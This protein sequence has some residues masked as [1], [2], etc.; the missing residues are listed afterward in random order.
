MEKIKKI[1]RYLQYDIWRI[2]IIGTQGRNI[3]FVK[4]LRMLILTFKGFIEDNCVLRAS[5]LTFFTL[6]SIVP[7]FAMAFGIAKGFGLDKNL[8]A[9]LKIAFQGQQE[10]LNQILEF[11][12]NQLERT[13]GGMVAGLGVLL[14]FW[15]I[16]KLMGNMENALN[17]IWG[18]KMGRTLGRKIVEYVIV[19]VV[20][21]LLLI[22]S[23]GVTAFLTTYATLGVNKFE[24]LQF[25]G[26]YLL[27]SLK[28]VPL[29]FLWALFSFL[30]TFMPNTKVSILSGLFA[31]AVSALLFDLTQFAYF[32]FQVVLFTQYSAIYGS[33]AAMPLFLIWLEVSWMIFLLGAEIA[34]SHQ[35]VDTF[36]FDHDIKKISSR[37][38]RELQLYVAALIAE[39]FEN[40]EPPLS[41]NQLTHDHAMPY[42]LAKMIL[43]DLVKAGVATLVVGNGIHEEDECYQPALTTAKLTVESVSELLES[44]GVDDIP[45]NK[46]DKFKRVSEILEEMRMNNRKSKRN[47][48]LAKI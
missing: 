36:E 39:R 14:L 29:L 5:S 35:N 4:Q 13:A 15:T 44:N 7:I 31:G 8:E 41:L 21:P 10:I 33:F 40:G 22:M 18:V 45:F 28:F 42:R 27:L 46:D 34:F 24:F 47:V 6:L 1:L 37:Y 30:Y 23:Q 25:F 2:R 48:S 12:H 3:W 11:S 19:I 16:I 26:P 43:D 17:E 32:K 20:A 9:Q 38:R